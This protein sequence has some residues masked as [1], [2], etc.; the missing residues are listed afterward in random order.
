MDASRTL[1]MTS[2]F[3][4][5]AW[6]KSQMR[7]ENSVGVHGLC[8]NLTIGL[9][10]RRLRRVYALYESP[11]TERPMC[12]IFGFGSAELGIA[13]SEFQEMVSE[14]KHGTTVKEYLQVLQGRS[15]ENFR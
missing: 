5:K 8:E 14:D 2:G 7:V 4:G 9:H 6:L 1:S 12:F 13:P 10:G 3:L 11:T 15:G